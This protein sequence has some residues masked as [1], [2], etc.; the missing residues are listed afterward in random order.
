MKTLEQVRD[1]EIDFPQEK[2]TI[3][4]TH[5]TF[6]IKA[7]E[8]SRV[9]VSI[10]DGR[11]KPCRMT[12]GLWWYDWTPCVPGDHTLEARAENDGQATAITPPRC[13]TVRV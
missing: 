10:D 1:V 4:S 5:Y 13:F 8:A 12:D 6:R 11:W 2:E 7:R 9:F 3:T